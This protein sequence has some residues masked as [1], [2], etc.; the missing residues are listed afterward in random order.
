MKYYPFFLFIMFFG[1]SFYTFAQKDSIVYSEENLSDSDF[2]NTKFYRYTVKGDDVRIRCLNCG[3]TRETFM[4]KI[5]LTN[6][7]GG[8]YIAGVE[9]KS[10]C[11]N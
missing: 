10:I 7:L 1:A 2:R 5:N 8:K 9:Q 6:M 3:K 11:P 4:F